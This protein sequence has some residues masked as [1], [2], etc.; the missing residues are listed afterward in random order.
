MRKSFDSLCC[1]V[2]DELDSYLTDGTAYLIDNKLRDKV[3]ILHLHRGVF[4]IYYKRLEKGTF[5][6]P[7]YSV[8]ICSSLLGAIVP[9]IPV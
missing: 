5:E 4:I 7:S 1:I 8:S 9:A 3:K 6:V 2:E